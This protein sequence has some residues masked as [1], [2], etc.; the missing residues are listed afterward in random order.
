MQ[1]EI[2]VGDY[3]RVRT[4]GKE[5][6]V[7]AMDGQ[8]GMAEVVIGNMRM[9]IGKNYVERISRGAERR[10]EGRAGRQIQVNVT[11]IAAPEINVRGLRVEEALVEVDR[12]VDRAIVH[13]TPRLKILHGIGTGRLM[14]A[15]REHLSEAGYIKDVKKDEANSGVTIVELAMISVLDEVLEK[16]NIL[17]IVSQYVKLRRTGRN[18]VGLCPFHKEKTPSFTVNTEKQIYYCFGCH[19]GGNAVNFLAKY[20]RS[21]FSEALET[22]AHQVGIEAAGRLS[23]RRT[24]VIDALSRLADYYHESLKRYGPAMKYLERPADQRSRY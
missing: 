13:G 3:V 20:E 9:R 8:K 22:L 11:D 15:I 18:F 5:G 12:F 4:I 21:T 1:A 14:Q 7:A 23:A 19:E 10:A 17:D 2:A 16:V 24:P 6:Y